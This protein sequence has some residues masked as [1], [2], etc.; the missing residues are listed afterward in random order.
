MNLVTPPRGRRLAPFPP[1]LMNTKPGAAFP[2]KNR[3]RVFF[4]SDIR[5]T[6]S[7]RIPRQAEEESPRTID[8]GSVRD[9]N[10]HVHLSSKVRFNGRMSDENRDFREN[11]R[12]AK[13]SSRRFYR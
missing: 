3:K 13:K 7:E 6:L 8:S 2:E 1:A 4:R 9:Y 12:E 5:E 10:G 11:S